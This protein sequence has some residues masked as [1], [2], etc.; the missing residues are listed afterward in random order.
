MKMTPDRWNNVL[1]VLTMVAAYS[2]RDVLVAFDCETQACA[3]L[4][5]Y[6]Q[7]AGRLI[8]WL[9]KMAALTSEPEASLAAGAL[10]LLTVPIYLITMWHSKAADS[11]YVNT[12]TR[13]SVLAFMVVF[14]LAL[15]WIFTWEWFPYDPESHSIANRL[16]RLFVTTAI[17]WSIYSAGLPQLLASLIVWEIRFFIALI[18]W[19]GNR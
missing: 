16:T 8:P 10:C 5:A 3:W 4:W 12:V 14:P 11:A 7:W 18:R 1:G 15:I 2:I 17:G 6:A 19:I 13:K 9:G